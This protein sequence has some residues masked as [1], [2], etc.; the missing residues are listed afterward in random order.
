MYG[1]SDFTHNGSLLDER[2][3]KDFYQGMPAVR[4]EFLTLWFF[5]VE[6]HIAQRGH[7]P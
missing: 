4:V 5:E 1:S 6:H 3:I 7:L 2:V